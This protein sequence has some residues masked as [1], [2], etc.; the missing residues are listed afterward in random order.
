MLAY[1]IELTPDDNDTFLVTCPALPEVTTFG[2]TERDAREQA[3][4][5]I[6]E[7]LAARMVH[8]LD[9]PKPTLSEKAV[10]VPSRVA[11]K[12]LLYQSMKRQKITKYRLVKMLGVHQPQV[13]RLLDVR[14]N[15]NL[16]A[17][18]EAMKVLGETFVI[19]AIKH[20][21]DRSL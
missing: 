9:I 1:T 11:M 4:D 15:T 12:A 19:Q 16:D 6:V 7:A 20:Y 18:D 14:H 5:A 8:G 17:L 3:I 2:E 13:D 21:G 10:V